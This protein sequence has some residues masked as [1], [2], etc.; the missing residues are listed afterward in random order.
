MTQSVWPQT[1]L[2]VR[3]VEASSQFYCEIFGFE[4]GHGG[5]EYDQLLHR[6][7]MVMQLHDY[8]TEDHH[9]L[10]RKDGVSLGN[11]VLVCSRSLISRPR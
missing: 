2:V 7:E 6:G 8:N 3:D 4:S 9:G 5:S 10:L 11:G 1:M